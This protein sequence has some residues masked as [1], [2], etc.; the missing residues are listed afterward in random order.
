MNEQK[1][2]IPKRPEPLSI[3]THHTREAYRKWRADEV[4]YWDAVRA[5]GREAERE[6]DAQRQH[7]NR[8][9]SDTEYD[10]LCLQRE[11]ERRAKQLE[12][13][14]ETLRQ[15]REKEDFLA[16]S[17]EAVDLLETNP[18]TFIQGLAHWIRKMYEV[19]FEA[20]HYMQVG[21]YSAR[22]VKCTEQ[23]AAQSPANR[24]EVCTAKPPEVCSN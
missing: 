11:N 23:D 1:I 15:Q 16:S 5:A 14:A 4:A 12:R 13:E 21:M 7:A 19:D 6:L 10:E 18:V 22:L 8:I 9:L 24:P 2:T 20:P 3:Y 17:P